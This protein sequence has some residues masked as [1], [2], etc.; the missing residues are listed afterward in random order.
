MMTVVTPQDWHAVVVGYTMRP[1]DAAEGRA[2]GIEPIKG[3]LYSLRHS[4]EAVTVLWNGRVAALG[5]VAYVDDV[6]KP[7]LL[8]TPLV[9]VCPMWRL[10]G[11]YKRRCKKWVEMYGVLEN[12]VDASYTKAVRLLK[13]AGF[14]LDEPI[15]MPQT[16]AMFRRFEMRA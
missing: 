11:E 14:S 9:D 15:E 1:E 4:D 3:A 7:W 6:G 8:T 10:I 13:L 12:Y 5:G 2:L 16:G